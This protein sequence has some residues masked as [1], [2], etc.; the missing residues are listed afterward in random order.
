MLVLA[1]VL[2][3]ACEGCWPPACSFV[4]YCC[5]TAGQLVTWCWRW[6]SKQ[7]VR[8]AGIVP[9]VARRIAVRLQD[10]LSPGAGAGAGGGADNSLLA[11]CVLL[12]VVM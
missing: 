7:L 11:L 4:L 8:D 1:V 5:T 2:A 6:C 10:S 9:A 3:R 12:C